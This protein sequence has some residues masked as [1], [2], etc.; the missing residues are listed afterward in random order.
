MHNKRIIHCIYTHWI[1]EETDITRSVR[2]CD[3]LLIECTCSALPAS[4]FRRLGCNKE[5]KKKLLRFL[6]KELVGYCGY[7]SPGGRNEQNFRRATKKLV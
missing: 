2:V 5:R 7:G 4:A 1:I 3:F 6:L